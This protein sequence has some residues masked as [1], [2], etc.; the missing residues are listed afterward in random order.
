[1]TDTSDHLLPDL[2]RMADEIR[3][4]IHLAGLEAKDAWAKLEPRLRELE[5][6]VE[7]A[8]DQAKQQLVE[9]GDAMKRELQ[10][11]AARVTRDEDSSRR[12]TKP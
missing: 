6:K 10:E 4:R 7:R 2:R 11:L 8:T 1:M 9:L 12:D 3:V 5:H